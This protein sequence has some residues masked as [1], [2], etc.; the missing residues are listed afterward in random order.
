MV[1]LGGEFI[2]LG[3]RFGDA[4]GAR[5]GLR[6]V[7]EGLVGLDHGRGPAVDVQLESARR[8]RTGFR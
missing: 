2:E 3:L 6:A 8:S 1:A 7:V 4:G 5:L